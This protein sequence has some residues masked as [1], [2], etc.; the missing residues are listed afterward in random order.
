[1]KI[2]IAV[3]LC[4][5]TVGAGS[6]AAQN[7]P[8]VSVKKPF[9]EHMERKNS[10]GSTQ[11]L[12]HGGPV[13]LG[14]VPIYVIYYG[15]GFPAQTQDIV[16]SFLEGLSGTPQFI[17]NT[18]Y[19]EAQTTSC[20]S[21]Q[22]P[23]SGVL[24]Y[25]TNLSHTFSDPGS[26]G[27]QLNSSNITKVI[28]HAFQSGLPAIDDAMYILITAPTVK[29]PGFC[30]SFCAYHTYSTGFV[31]GHVIR[32]A[33]V[34]E[35]DSSCTACDGNFAVYHETSTPTGDAGADEVVDSIMH[36]LSEIVTD[37][38]LNAWYTANGAENGDLCNYKY[39][40]HT[41]TV[42][43]AT[44]NA[45]WKGYSYLIQQ[46]WANGPLPQGCAP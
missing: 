2:V 3:L 28:Q 20:G 24:D 21:G 41:F 14:N 36:E 33:F 18:T 25:P 4:V 37:P 46:I 26:Q 40:N 17:V 10:S 16:N 32:Y 15:I 27:M 23:V 31:S 13:L 39:G 45:T 44:A 12:W 1:M 35:P 22:S 42:N 6:L 19:C 38:N 7:G 9:G 8:D 30:S 34:P 11:I 43:G 5:L 29:V